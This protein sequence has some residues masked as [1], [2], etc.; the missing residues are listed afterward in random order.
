MSDLLGDRARYGTPDHADVTCCLSG[1]AK[2][3]APKKVRDAAV[4]HSLPGVYYTVKQGLTGPVDV[5]IVFGE[6]ITAKCITAYTDTY[7]H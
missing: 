3:V 7:G 2:L 1:F 4:R 6:D 5:A